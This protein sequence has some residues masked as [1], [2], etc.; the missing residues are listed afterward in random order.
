VNTALANFLFEAAN[1]LVLAGALAW[2]L[3]KPVRRVLDAE[4]ARHAESLEDIERQQSSLEQE[5]SSL[6]DEKRSMAQDLGQRRSEALDAARKEA[7]DLRA[8]AREAAEAERAALR[9]ELAARERAE[10]DGLVGEVGQ[11][12]AGTVERLLRELSGPALDL[13]LLRSVADQLDGMAGEATVES[14][15]PLDAEARALLD[16]ALPRGY[17][18]RVRP[19][20]GAGLRITSTSGQVD[21]SALGFAREVRTQLP[22]ELGRGE[23]DG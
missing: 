18:V 5:R 19:E 16:A 2:L 10:L 9:Q 15:R 22:L 13:A 1:F 17:Q 8:A 20:L 7:E 14:A 11:L 23:Q 21:V 12:A 4:R 3:F 6:A